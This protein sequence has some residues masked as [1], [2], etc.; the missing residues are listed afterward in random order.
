MS[1]LVQVQ[2]ATFQPGDLIDER[3]QVVDLLGIGAAGEVYRARLVSMDMVVALK[4]L[5][6]DISLDSSSFERLR[7]EARILGSI[8]HPNIAKVHG[9][10]KHGS[11]VYIAVA[12]VDGLPLSHILER[13][14]SLPPTKAWPMLVELADA[15]KALEAKGIVHR[16]IKPSNIMIRTDANGLLHPVLI[17]FGLAKKSDVVF[18]QHATKGG[19]L[20]GTPLYMSPEVCAG[21]PA[22][23]RS[24]IY[25]FGCVVLECLT[26]KP[27]FSG[28]SPLAIMLSHL[29][30]TIDGIPLFCEK[31]L[32]TCLN[33]DPAKRYCSFAALE[34][35]LVALTPTSDA[36]ELQIPRAAARCKKWN[37]LLIWTVLLCS[38]SVL[39]AFCLWKSVGVPPP[40]IAFQDWQDT[41]DRASKSGRL[42]AELHCMLA[43][44]SG[45][46]STNGK[47]RYYEILAGKYFEKGRRDKFAE[48]MEEGVQ[49][50]ARAGAWNEA[51]T[52]LLEV[53]GIEV[54][55]QQGLS[56]ARILELK[57]LCKFLD[58][59]DVPESH[60]WAG[61][62]SYYLTRDYYRRHEDE[63]AKKWLSRALS[64]APLS[65]SAASRRLYLGL[66]PFVG[67]YDKGDP[68]V[69]YNTALKAIEAVSYEY[70]IPK[71]KRAP[72]DA[73]ILPTEPM[74]VATEIFQIY[75]DHVLPASQL[76]TLLERTRDMLIQSRRSDAARGPYFD[77]VSCLAGADKLLGL[78]NE[79]HK[80]LTEA[81]AISHA[82]P[83]VGSANEMSALSE[84]AQDEL[85]S[86]KIDEAVNLAQFALTK[87]RFCKDPHPL[88]ACFN[89]LAECY[90]IKQDLEQAQFYFAKAYETGKAYNRQA[91]ESDNRGQLTDSA[92]YMLTDAIE[93]SKCL[94]DLGRRAEALKVVTE[95]IKLRDGLHLPDNFYHSLD[96]LKKQLENEPG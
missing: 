32:R 27:P 12:L 33:K 92:I 34:D 6:T 10:G 77:Y 22:T 23:S 95:A 44:L 81:S 40:T 35:D 88:I 60:N 62:A 31:I 71:G 91:L 26:G 16:D 59:H 58:E 57:Q 11:R 13:D 38:I 14:G 48:V 25:S 17:D 83:N 54:E 3:Y 52:L 68:K 20:L 78:A 66:L 5:R 51:R 82:K 72:L 89:I 8:D 79:R 28:E 96:N 7:N 74:V 49:S 73:A 15:L 67:L 55:G 9:F 19:V 1:L 37:G 2:N 36:L 24:D 47:A 69:V 43:S 87:V 85:E 94:R 29:H 30:E 75:A 84:L 21:Q 53:S 50:L 65:D 61:Q 70:E 41:V 56:D 45:I 90:R 18:G 46:P 42:D 4:I 86:G 93:L 76:K 63:N 39:L 80:L 64:E